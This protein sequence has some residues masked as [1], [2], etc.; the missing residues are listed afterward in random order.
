MISMISDESLRCPVHMYISPSFPLA[1]HLQNCK[2]LTTPLPHETKT[3]DLQ[4]Q[5][6]AIRFALRFTANLVV[7]PQLASPFRFAAQLQH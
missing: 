7:L 3:L 4:P 2:F 5:V 1:F 6:A